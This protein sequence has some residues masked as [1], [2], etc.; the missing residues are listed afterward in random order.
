MRTL[1]FFLSLLVFSIASFAQEQ[2]TITGSLKDEATGNPVAFATVAI[3]GTKLATGTDQNGNFSIRTSSANPTL[4]FTSIGYEPKEV[5]YTG[6]EVLSV[7]LKSKNAALTEVVVTALGIK[8]S[9]NYK[10]AFL[11]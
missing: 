10:L 7:S 3:K 1:L 5:N 9:K 8:K 11:A 6:N 4:I 2:K